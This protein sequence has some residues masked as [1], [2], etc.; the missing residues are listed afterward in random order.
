MENKGW[1]LLFASFFIIIL[2]ASISAQE[3]STEVFSQQ[4]QAETQWVWGSII[5]VDTQKNE[6]LIKYLDYETDE[7]KELVVAVDEKTTLENVKSLSEIVA[8]DTASID[9]IT[10][11][12]GKNLAQNISVEKPQPEDAP[13][14]QTAGELSP[15]DLEGAA[16]AEE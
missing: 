13:G 12:D 15:Q 11:V 9:Y 2:T 1:K 5:S 14:T 10:T 8:A 3:F 4:A 16:E 7:E 6:I